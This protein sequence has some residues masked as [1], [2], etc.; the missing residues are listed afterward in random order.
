ML[1]QGHTVS[2]RLSDGSFTFFNH[3]AA[4]HRMS[5][6]LKAIVEHNSVLVLH[7]GHNNT[8]NTNAGVQGVIAQCGE[9]SVMRAAHYIGQ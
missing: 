9:M 6:N 7:D 8:C 1:L 2:G 4:M 3:S 5:D